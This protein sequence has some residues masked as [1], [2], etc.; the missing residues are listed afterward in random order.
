MVKILLKSKQIIPIVFIIISLC[1][2]LPRAQGIF[3]PQDEFGYWNNTAKILGIDWESVAQG[4]DRYAYGYSLFLI[5]LMGFCKDAVFMYKLAIVLNGLLAVCHC[6]LLLKLVD[7]IFDGEQHTEIEGL[8]RVFIGLTICVYPT[9]LLY[10]HYSTAEV[11][12][13]VLFTLICHIML[14][15]SQ[16]DFNIKVVLLGIAISICLF[17]THNRTAGI[18]AAFIMCCVIM[19]GETYGKSIGKPFTVLVY[20]LVFFSIVCIMPHKLSFDIHSL[21]QMSF[22]IAGKIYYIEAATFGM[23]FIGFIFCF[24]RSSEAFYRFLFHSFVLTCMIGSFFFLDGRRMDQL[25]YGR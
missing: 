3:F 9:S 8:T 23:A 15:I 11:L 10:M 22:G 17:A 21:L 7:R 20:I 2:F 13:N 16:N 1:V 4:Q 6:F 25:I 19:A 5:P 14:S 18:L 24:S 12:I